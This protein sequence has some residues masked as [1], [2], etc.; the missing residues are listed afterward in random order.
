MNGVTVQ[1]QKPLGFATDA[2][3]VLIGNGTLTRDIAADV[4]LLS[5]IKLDPSRQLIGA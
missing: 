3:A 1:R 4:D 5:R 2:D